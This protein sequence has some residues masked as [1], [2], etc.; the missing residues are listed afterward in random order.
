MQTF[1]CYALDTQGS[2]TAAE[3]VE[4]DDLDAAIEAGWRFVAAHNA[5][6][7]TPSF[8]LE[9]WHGKTLLFTTRHGPTAAVS[10]LSGPVRPPVPA[11]TN[12]DAEMRNERARTAC[13]ALRFA[14]L[15]PM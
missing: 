14:C 11:D 1:R 3:N 9:I 4:A 8:G 6:L 5:G 10:G 2:I 13:T 15:T 12:P 7:S